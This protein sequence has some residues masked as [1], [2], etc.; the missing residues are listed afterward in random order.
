[1]RTN[2][3]VAAV[4]AALLGGAASADDVVREIIGEPND[5]TGWDVAGVGDVNADLIPDFVVGS[6]N[7]GEVRV[8]SGAN[9]VELST[10]LADDLGRGFG[11][12]VK[13]MAS[14]DGDAVRDILVGHN[15]GSRVDAP[16][17]QA[18]VFSGATGTRLLTVTGS[19]AFDR[20]GDEVADAGDV[21]NDGTPD[22]V[23]GA[24]GATG[25][26]AG[27][28][29]V[30]S[31]V[32]GAEL[33]DLRR[34][35]S[36]NNA[37]LGRAVAGVGDL[38]GD[39]FDDVAYGAPGADPKN[40]NR[41]VVGLVEIVS[42]RDGTSIRTL[43]GK[44]P[45]ASFGRAIQNVGDVDQDGID[46]LVVASPSSGPGQGN[47]QVYS[48]KKG[49]LILVVPG[50]DDRLGFGTDLAAPGDVDID[51]IPDVIVG[52]NGSVY[53][54]SL[55]DGRIL[56]Q[57][58]GDE[59]DGTG[60]FVDGVGDV[61]ND[62]VPDLIVG[63]WGVDT[64]RIVAVTLPPPRI[65]FAISATFPL[66]R[67]GLA[68]TARGTVRVSGK[69]TRFTLFGKLVGMPPP[70]TPLTAFLEDA[71]DADTFSHI[72]DVTVTNVK[73]GLAEFA[74][75]GDGELPPVL[76][77]ESIADLTGRR[78]QIRYG[79]A[80]IVLDTPIPLLGKP[81][82][83]KVKGILP[84]APDGPLDGASAKITGKFKGSSGTTRLDVKAKGVDKKAVYDVF[85]EDDVGSGTFSK[86]GELR[87]GKFRAD[88]K[89]GDRLP[90]GAQ[91][92]A[93]LKGKKLQVRE[94]D[95]DVVIEGLI[96]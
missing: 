22:F 53:V 41:P 40:Q 64:A 24:P 61:T 42:G 25:S 86:A 59:F 67:P 28:A 44:E 10:L 75:T 26:S 82:N 17:G 23:V 74:L 72:A 5:L 37:N 4:L 76:N 63:A 70:G 60:D 20:F 77:A 62:A 94:Q 15:R 54:V 93:E 79:L 36:S 19:R 57:Y 65:Q 30:Y 51:G 88:S 39:G 96:P 91:N 71:R 11:V 29:R 50:P 14:I 47:L 81:P 8:I 85:V 92:L 58:D 80:E 69:G 1:M 33:I 3:C 89:K 13:S 95:G 7:T 6:E 12:S 31:G 38:D 55:A 68:G 83:G 18:H 90:G 66:T 2:V 73:K 52:A 56:F 43:K 46:D 34:D 45:G 9:G 21:N 48:G 16:A 49:K 84:Q 27:S 87:K 32:N 35:G 78:L